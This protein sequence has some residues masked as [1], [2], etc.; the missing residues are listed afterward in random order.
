M[1]ADACLHMSNI[2]TENLIPTSSLFKKYTFVSN[3]FKLF[4][5]W[6]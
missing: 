1:N 6:L 3:K 2:N 4:Y 5:V